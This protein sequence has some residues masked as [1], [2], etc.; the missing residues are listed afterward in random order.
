MDNKTNRQKQLEKIKSLVASENDIESLGYLIKSFN[1]LNKDALNNVESTKQDILSR[2]ETLRES[3]SSGREMYILT[4]YAMDIGENKPTTPKISFTH[5]EL[6]KKAS[7]VLVIES[8]FSDSYGTN[9]TYELQLSN[10]S[11]DETTGLKANENISLTAADTTSDTIATIK[12]RAVSPSGITSD[13]SDEISIKIKGVV[14]G[15]FIENL[16]TNKSR[17]IGTGTIEDTQWLDKTLPRLNELNNDDEVTKFFDREDMPHSHIK[18]Y[19]I[20]NDGTKEL[21]TNFDPNSYHIQKYKN[22]ALWQCFSKIPAHH[23]IDI[24]FTYQ[25]EEYILKLVSLN[26]FSFDLNAYGFV[27]FTNCKGRGT[28]KNGIISSVAEYEFY[29]GSWEAVANG[30][31]QGSFFCFDKKPT[32]SMTRANFRSQIEAF[33]QSGEKEADSSDSSDSVDS[34]ADSGE[35]SMQGSGLAFD[36]RQKFRIYNYYER[37]AIVNLYLTERGYMGNTFGEKR[38]NESKWGMFSWY[39]GA[40]S[41]GYLSESAWLECGNKSMVKPWSSSDLRVRNNS[42]RGICNLAGSV[43]EFIDGIYLVDN[44]VYLQDRKKKY[45]DSGEE[46]SNYKNSGMLVEANNDAYVK[47]LHSGE[48]IPLS[49]NG[50]SNMIGTTDYCYKQGGTRLVLVGGNC[51]DVNIA[52]VLYWYSYCGFGDNGW[53]AGSRGSY[54][55]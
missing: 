40:N 51:G 18:R 29:I 19:A 11:A 28:N 15:G 27:G 39:S 13:W 25:S 8:A 32:S 22:S 26:P 43:H 10:L 4:K 35:A 41:A 2:I 17:R 34:G 49:S 6:T 14:F 16:N 24:E 55:D 36:T 7:G 46:Y 21:L 47:K 12:A 3:A 52:G 42:Y 5:K 45:V 50:A 31:M 38:T 23:I 44:L 9:L 33:G 54:K 20:K 37:R 48:L 30:G 53:W 1:D